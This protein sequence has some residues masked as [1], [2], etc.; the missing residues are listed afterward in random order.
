[1]GAFCKCHDPGL[2][3]PKSEGRNPKQIQIPNRP[4]FKTSRRSVV[5][6]IPLLVLGICFGLRISILGF[7]S[8]ALVG[9]V[10]IGP[11]GAPGQRAEN[12][13]NTQNP[14]CAPEAGW[15]PAVPEGQSASPGGLRPIAPSIES[16][17]E[18][19]FIRP[20]GRLLARIKF[21]SPGMLT[22]ERKPMEHMIISFTPFWGVSGAG[23]HLDFLRALIAVPS[24]CT[25]SA[26]QGMSV[27]SLTMTT[28]SFR[29]FRNRGMI[30]VGGG[31][32]PT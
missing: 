5:L 21:S 9:A 16:S 1:M 32:L 7:E 17:E 2:G 4:M 18:P 31:W 25:V 3:N 8:P 20:K 29:L 22:A 23:G 13:Q 10:Q 11:G 24:L 6:V 28:I 27:M 12:S 30:A 14:I 15:P 19:G 26:R